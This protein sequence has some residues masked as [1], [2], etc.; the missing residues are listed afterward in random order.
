MELLD[1]Q[2]GFQDSI[3]SVEGLVDEY[4]QRT[5]LALNKKDVMST[6]AKEC[7][8]DGFFVPI[9]RYTWLRGLG[10]FS[11]RKHCI[12]KLQT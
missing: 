4:T 12:S 9:V 8:V 3:Y 2:I 7:K 6:S 11:R 5:A 10:P 1:H